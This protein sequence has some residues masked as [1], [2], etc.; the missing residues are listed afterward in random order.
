[1]KLVVAGETASYT[2]LRGLHEK[3]TEWVFDT[4]VEF[5]GKQ[6]YCRDLQWYLQD[7]DMVATV[8]SYHPLVILLEPYDVYLSKQNY[9]AN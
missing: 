9:K 5:N 4:P 2:M 3:H 6:F 1:M 7:G 8:K